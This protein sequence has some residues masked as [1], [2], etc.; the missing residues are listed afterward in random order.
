MDTTEVIVAIASPPGPAARGIVRLA[1]DGLHDVLRKS[2]LDLTPERKR[3]TTTLQ[4]KAPL[5]EVPVDVLMWP[6]SHSYVGQPSAELN[7]WGAPVVLD[8]IVEHCCQAG[9]RLAGPGEFT[10]RAFLAGRLDLSQAEAVLGVIDAETPDDLHIALAQL[11]GNLSRPLGQLR[12]QGLNLLA[13]V[14]A[15]LDF[16]DEDI[17]FVSDESLLRQLASMHDRLATTAQ[18]LHDRDATH[19]EVRVSIRGYPNA[20]KS[21]LL[22]RLVGHDAAIV[23]DVAGTTRDGVVAETMIDGKRFR[24]ED[25]AGIERHPDAIL[26]EANRRASDADRIAQLRLWC[27]DASDAAAA[28]QRIE[29]LA[30]AKETA[31]ASTID[32][33]VSTKAD[34]LNASR[35]TQAGPPWLAISA[36]SGHGMDELRQQVVAVTGDVAGHA[37]LVVPGTSRRCREVLHHAAQC[38]A[39]AR[40]AAAQRAGHEI[41]A[42]ELRQAIE[43]IGHVTGVVYT[44]DILDRVFG[45]FCIGK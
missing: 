33:F 9:G 11:A 22:N 7:T 25:T 38:I 39:S 32:L 17:E 27:V 34:R 21:Y 6:D 43:L 44:D 4:L 2:G 36:L 18:Q 28:N 41:V 16:V 31:R 29:L 37:G 40:E 30:T 45:R 26:A 12:E 13:D 14:E 10:M 15:G 42:A 3:H 20:G 23:S 19:D 24:F 1:G 35:Q 8:A 5:G